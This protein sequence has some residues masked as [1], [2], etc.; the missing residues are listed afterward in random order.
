MFTALIFLLLFSCVL[1]T[2][3]VLNIT[4][5]FRAYKLAS[6]RESLKPRSGQKRDLSHKATQ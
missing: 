1:I 6:F 2:L 4:C 3:N 5:L